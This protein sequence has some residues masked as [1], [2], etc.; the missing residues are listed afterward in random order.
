MKYEQRETSRQDIYGIHYKT[1]IST[2][3]TNILLLDKW[4]VYRIQTLEQHI[5]RIASVCLVAFFTLPL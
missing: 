4:G 5:L 3:T 1:Y 2:A